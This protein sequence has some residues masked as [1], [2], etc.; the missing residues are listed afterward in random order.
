M[1]R[2]SFLKWFMAAAPVAFVASKLP[3]KPKRTMSTKY[4]GWEVLPMK[5]M[6]SA[7]RY[8]GYEAIPMRLGESL[9]NIYSAE[10]GMFHV[11][12]L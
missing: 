8:S 4:P 9:T 6:G 5:Q 11:K 12:Q 10:D 3:E 7:V 2:R 1:K